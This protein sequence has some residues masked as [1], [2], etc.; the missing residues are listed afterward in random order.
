MLA[1]AIGVDGAIKRHIRRGVAGD[2]VPRGFQRHLGFQRRQIGQRIPAIV[3]IDPRQRLKSPTGIDG[4]AS[5]TPQC[6]C[7]LP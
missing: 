7:L 3:H 4:G 6:L 5:A 2:D 1:A